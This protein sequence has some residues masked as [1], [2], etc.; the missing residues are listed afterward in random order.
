RNRKMIR[1]NLVILTKWVL[2]HSDI[3][4]FIP[5]QAGGI[6]FLKYNMKI[7]SAEFAIKLREEKSVFIVAGDCFGMDHYI[8]I[9]IGSEKDFLLAGLKLIDEILEELE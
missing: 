8:R 1:E 6:A 3:F 9:G 5:P 2:K 4:Q 7:N